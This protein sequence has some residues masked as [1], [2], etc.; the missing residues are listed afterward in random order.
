MTKDKQYVGLTPHKE[1]IE[2]IRRVAKAAAAEYSRSEK[3]VPDYVEAA[4]NLG[5]AVGKRRPTKVHVGAG[6]I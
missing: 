1:A 4:T 3:S 5:Q 6:M 2:R